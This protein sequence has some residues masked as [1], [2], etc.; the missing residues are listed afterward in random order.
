MIKTHFLE[1]I[2]KLSNNLI[3][4]ICVTIFRGGNLFSVELHVIQRH[5]MLCASQ[6]LIIYGFIVCVVWFTDYR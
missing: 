4:F 3:L 5:S 2:I 6:L 1:I